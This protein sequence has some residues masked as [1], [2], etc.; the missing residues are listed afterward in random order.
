MLDT[1]FVENY[2]KSII[3]LDLHIRNPT[4]N[5]IHSHREVVSYH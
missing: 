5:S 1:L 2:R 4:Y 3:R